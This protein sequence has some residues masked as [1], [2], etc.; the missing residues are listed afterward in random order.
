MSDKLNIPKTIP[1]CECGHYKAMH[2]SDR[3]LLIEPQPGETSIC[4]GVAP[5][6]SKVKREAPDEMPNACPCVRFKDKV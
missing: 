2:Y 5:A 3:S 1:V 4:I 6:G